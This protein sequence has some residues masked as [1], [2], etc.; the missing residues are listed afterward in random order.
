M[1]QQRWVTGSLRE[2]QDWLESY[3]ATGRRTI[4]GRRFAEPGGARKN[5][6][7]L[8]EAV[9]TDW[10]KFGKAAEETALVRLRQAQLCSPYRLRHLGVWDAPDGN[11]AHAERV[12]ERALKQVARDK[13][14]EW[15]QLDKRT[16][17]DVA[18]RLFGPARDA[19]RGFDTALPPRDT[20]SGQRGV[21]CCGPGHS[22]S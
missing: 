3:E 21:D 20:D 10:V 19:S 22:T 8:T 4:I 16:A 2:I 13:R 6:V 15:V 1:P 5:V 9:G 14:W 18:V 11:A 17:V 12:L 7:Y